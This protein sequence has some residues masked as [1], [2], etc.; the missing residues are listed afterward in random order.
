MMLY[1]DIC[2]GI[3]VAKEL[4]EDKESFETIDYMY[5]YRIHCNGVNIKV[6]RCGNVHILIT[7]C[8]TALYITQN[9]ARSCDDG[10]R[11][12]SSN[13]PTTDYF[14]SM[15]LGLRYSFL[16]QHTDGGEV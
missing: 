6:S 1:T 16:E 13:K 4:T 7:D 14:R 10:C 8:K 3:R 15:V 11:P 12:T 2:L 5:D 9:Q